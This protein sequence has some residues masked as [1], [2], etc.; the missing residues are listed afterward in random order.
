MAGG[1]LGGVLGAACRLIPGYAESWIKT[2]FY[3]NDTVSQL[4]SMTLFAGLCLYLW[5]GSTRSTEEA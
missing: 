2:P 3:D 5:Y 1:A 4:V